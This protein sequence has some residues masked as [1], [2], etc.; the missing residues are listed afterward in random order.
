M[1]KISECSGR[2]VSA[3]EIPTVPA[4]PFLPLLPLISR[5]AKHWKER[6]RW[7]KRILRE[8]L[9]P[10]SLLAPDTVRY[11][12]F[13]GFGAKKISDETAR[14]QTEWLFERVF[15]FGDNSARGDHWI[16]CLKN[17]PAHDNVVH[18]GAHC[19]GGRHDTLLIITLAIGGAGVGG[20]GHKPPPG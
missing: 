18:P 14:T 7:Q 19:M 17:R 4:A 6:C 13:T 1:E 2:R 8:R 5:A 3:A 10:A 12:T 9:A 11:T 15:H 16:A 20:G